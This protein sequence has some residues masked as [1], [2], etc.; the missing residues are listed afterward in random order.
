MPVPVDADHITIAKPSSKNHSV[1]KGVKKF[2]Q[3][4]LKPVRS[5][6]PATAFNILQERISEKNT[7]PYQPL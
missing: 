2:V 3:K 7:D 4:H 1:Y 6:P 5:L